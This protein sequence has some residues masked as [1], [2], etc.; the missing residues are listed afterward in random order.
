MTTT[1]PGLVLH[2][3]KPE[4]WESSESL[5]W[6]H[7]RVVWLHADVAARSELYAVPGFRDAHR[8]IGMG[9]SEQSTTEEVAQLRRR[10]LDRARHEGVANVDDMG[11][12]TLVR[13]SE[14]PA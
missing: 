1:R 3:R 4:L 14:Q 2:L 5:E 13:W 7:D 8:H 9:W 12:G 6:E 11:L 10:D